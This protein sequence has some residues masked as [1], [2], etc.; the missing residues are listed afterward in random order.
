MKGVI[1][2]GD[3]YT[4]EAGAQ[5]LKNGGNAYDAIC[6]AML[7]SPLSEPMLTSV[8]GGGFLLS[9]QKN[10][11]AELYDFFVDVPENRVENKDFYPIGVDF[12][13]TIQ[14]FHIGTASIAIPGVLKGIYEIHKEKGR[15]PLSDIIEPAKK[16]ASEGLYLS[17]MQ[18]H[19]VQLL[20]PILLSTPASK[21]LYTKNDELIDHNHLFKNPDYA[22]F[23]KEFAKKGDKIFYD[24]AIADSIDSLS[25]QNGGDIRK[26][27]LKD[28]KVVKREPIDFKF[29]EFEILTNT[30]PS[31][32]GILIAFALKLLEKEDLGEFGSIAHISKLIEAMVTTSEFRSEHINEFLHKAKLSDILDD[33]KLLDGYLKAYQNRV[34]LWGNTTHISVLDS[35]GNAATATTT[36]GEG[37]GVIVP[38]CGI[39]LNNMLG[40]EDLNPHGFFSWP[41]GVRLPSMMA[42]TI[43]LKNNIPKMVLGSAGSNRIRSAITQSILNYCVFGHDIKEVC[44]EK[45]L[46]FEKG[47]LFFEPGFDDKLI[48]KVKEHYPTTLFHDKSVFFGGVNAVTSDLLGGCDPRR[49]GYVKVV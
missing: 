43:V 22:V 37:S 20:E 4:S 3:K 38:N 6:A 49:G 23:L 39:M 30:P 36:N 19:F 28:Y 10:K 47:E 16:L 33:K 32:G 34:N 15:L 11:G 46:H 13:T 5:V 14:E 1:S 35:D 17:K 21:K 29:K 2:S 8:G 9:Y 24:G 12:G 44:E 31:A 27:D 40:E 25:R 26:E 18:A 41:K 45:R 42:P 7:T 48:Q